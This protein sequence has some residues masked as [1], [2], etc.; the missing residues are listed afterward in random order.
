MKYSFTTRFIH[1]YKTFSIPIQKKFDKQLKYLLTNLKHPSL[2][3]KKFDETFSIW[4]ARVDRGV[5]FYFLIKK[6]TYILLDIKHH[7]K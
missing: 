3:A 2:K 6:D 4:Q 1:S 5:R 7:A